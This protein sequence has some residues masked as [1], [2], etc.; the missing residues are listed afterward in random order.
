MYYQSLWSVEYTDMYTK[1]N[2]I[3]MKCKMYERVK[4]KAWQKKKIITLLLLFSF[5]FFYCQTWIRR[6]IIR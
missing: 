4:A 2:D 5:Y 3:Q 6:V 1:R